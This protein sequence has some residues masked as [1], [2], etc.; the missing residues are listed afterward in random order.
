MKIF[1]ISKYLFFNMVGLYV[2]DYIIWNLIIEIFEICYYVW[3]L[4]IN[5]FGKLRLIKMISFNNFKLNL[6][7]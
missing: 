4:L 6:F 2:M 3:S 5:I 1:Y 7:C